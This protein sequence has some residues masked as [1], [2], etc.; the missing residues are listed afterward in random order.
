[1]AARSD[2]VLLT[3]PVVAVGK[4]PDG[5]PLKLQT[6][7]L[8]IGTKDKQLQTQMPVLLTGPTR[9]IQAVGMIA[10]WDGKSLKLLNEVE[11]H[12]ARNR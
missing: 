3:G 8:L 1:M 7:R 6:S 9:Q 5:E 4:A 11:V 10:N 12:Y 2:D